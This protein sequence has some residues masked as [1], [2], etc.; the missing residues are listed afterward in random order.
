MHHACVFVGCISGPLR[1]SYS[2]R[3]ALQVCCKSPRYVPYKRTYVP[4]N[5]TFGTSDQG[6]MLDV[7]QGEDSLI[8]HLIRQIH[9]FNISSNPKKWNHEKYCWIGNSATILI[10]MDKKSRDFHPMAIQR[11]SKDYHVRS[12]LVHDKI[13][14]GVKK[15]TFLC[16]WHCNT[17]DSLHATNRSLSN[18]ILSS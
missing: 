4:H 8:H 10:H 13:L 9:R 1:V 16:C 5:G 6:Q 14:S 15:Y 17:Q 18:R 3:A 11:P 12:D 7:W 2:Q